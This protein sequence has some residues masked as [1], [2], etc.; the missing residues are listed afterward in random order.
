MTTI[1]ILKSLRPQQWIKN[2][3]IFAPLIF[4]RNILNGPLL[5]KTVEALV[6]FCLVSSAHYIFNDLRDIEE[7]RKHPVKSQRP[8]ASGRLKEVRTAEE[9]AAAS[10]PLA[11]VEVEFPVAQ[12]DVAVALERNWRVHVAA[13]AVCSEPA[14]SASAIRRRALLIPR[15]ISKPR[16]MATATPI[17]IAVKPKVF[18]TPA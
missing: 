5:L 16:L 11:R 13:D 10:A 18:M 17:I 1:E 8:L 3:F 2:L 6:A 14:P 7:D 9:T 4:S 15:L 12:G